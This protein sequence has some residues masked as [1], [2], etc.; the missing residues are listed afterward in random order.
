MVAPGGGEARFN[1]VAGLTLMMPMAEWMERR[2]FQKSLPSTSL[3]VVY[4]FGKPE[5]GGVSRCRCD[6][7]VPMGVRW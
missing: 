1:G 6:G 3:M 7:E 2:W 5:I 4:T